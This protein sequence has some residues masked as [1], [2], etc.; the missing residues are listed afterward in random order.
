MPKQVPATNDVARFLDHLGFEPGDVEPL[1]GGD[2]SSAFAFGPRTRR[3]VVRFGLHADDY[4][5]DRMAARWSSAQLPVPEFHAMGEV[6]RDALGLDVGGDGDACYA[7]T[8]FVA[9]TK[10]NALPPERAARVL[11]ALF[12]ALDT[13]RM[14]EPGGEGFGLWTARGDPPAVTAPHAHW[15]DAL[16]AIAHRDDARLAGWRGALALHAVPAAVFDAAQCALEDVARHCPDERR[17]IHDDL[18]YGNVLV[19]DDD[20]IAAVLDWGTAQVGDP[21]HEV[22]AL[23]F[24]APWYPVLDA[25][26]VEQLARRMYPWRDVAQRVVA[27]QLA[28][29]LGAMQYQAFAGYTD[30]LDATAAHTQRLLDRLP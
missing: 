26:L 22:A 12:E 25:V 29:A 28:M 17:L 8:T 14:L 6:P 2:W 13:L 16:C 24:W 4:A 5:K 15:R 3:R 19:G 18:L 7:I 9:G 21:V 30:H 11:P 27:C 20:R 10:L 23:L 1:H